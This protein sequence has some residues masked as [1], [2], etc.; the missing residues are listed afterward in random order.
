MS[1]GLSDEE[2]R[3]VIAE[4][5]EESGPDRVAAR[6]EAERRAAELLNARAGEMT[7]AE[8]VELI[9]LFNVDRIGEQDRQNRFV[10]AFTGDLRNRLV[11][12]LE[13]VNAYTHRLWR[14]DEDDALAALDEIFRDRAALPAAGRSYPSMLLYL[15]DPQRFKVSL[16][17]TNQ[18]LRAATGKREHPRTEGKEGYLAFCAAVAEFEQRYGLD[19]RE[20]DF[21]LA[22]LMREQRDR[23]RH[24]AAAPTAEVGEVDSG[25]QAVVDATYL[26]VELV[27][28]WDGLLRGNKR[29]AL[30]YGPPGTGKTYVAVQ[31]ARHLAGPHGE[32]LQVQFHPAYTYEDFIEGL[33]PA[34]DES[35]LRYEVRPGAFAELCRRAEANEAADHVLVIDEINRADLNAVLGEL[36]YCLEYRDREVELPYSQRPFSVPANVVVLATMNTADRSLALVDFAMR[37][38]FHALPLQPNRQVLEGW[39][40]DHPEDGDTALRF[41]D[42]ITDRVGAW[43]AAP[44]HSYWMADDLTPEGL[45]RIWRYELRPYLAEYWAE[46]R[47]LLEQLD[48]EVAELLGEEA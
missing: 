13:V 4:K 21:V 5:R 1:N 17:A 16:K 10:P 6:A 19:P 30:L 24:D 40:D 25:L 43:E 44:G 38:R 9:G 22:A 8:A 12:N 14:G 7:E 36:L 37:R 34:S 18:G 20:T 35:G 28:E 47:Q 29:Q 11:A 42:L 32:V 26:P 45:D 15:R 2:V 48:A 39:L 41:F 31:L 27:E 33:R 3:R 23:T 46:R